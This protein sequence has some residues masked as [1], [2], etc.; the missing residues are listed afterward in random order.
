MTRVA[1][2]KYALSMSMAMAMALTTICPQLALA[3]G[4]GHVVVP[5]P[6][7]IQTILTGMPVSRPQTALLSWTPFRPARKPARTVSPTLSPRCK[8][9]STA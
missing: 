6:D 2:M 9:T 3:H 4:D 1:P 7:C 8:P 5:S